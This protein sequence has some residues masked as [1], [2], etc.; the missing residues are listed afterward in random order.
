MVD[1]GL[2]KNDEVYEIQAGDLTRLYKAYQRALNDKLSMEVKV[3]AFEIVE[4]K[5]RVIY[6]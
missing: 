3:A 5:E 4:R 6:G 2:I 1:N